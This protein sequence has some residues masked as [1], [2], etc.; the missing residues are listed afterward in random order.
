MGNLPQIKNIDIDIRMLKACFE[1]PVDK[2]NSQCASVVSKVKTGQSNNVINDGSPR[3]PSSKPS[4]CRMSEGRYSIGTCPEQLEE[5]VN[6]SF[7]ITDPE[8]TVNKEP[9]LNQKL[10]PEEGEPQQWPT[11]L[12]EEL[13]HKSTVKADMSVQDQENAALLQVPPFG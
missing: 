11:M 1:I 5:A 13:G 6:R 7:G 4:Q 8:S 3:T 10:L 2:S 12:K 9:T